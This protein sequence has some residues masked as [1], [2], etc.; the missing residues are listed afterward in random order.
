MY[1]GVL[2]KF[3][4]PASHH[5]PPPPD[6]LTTVQGSIGWYPVHSYQGD[7]RGQ[8]LYYRRHD[9]NDGAALEKTR[10]WSREFE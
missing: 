6:S 2:I 10:I 1:T 4:N 7:R 5:S 3:N 9:D 8:Q